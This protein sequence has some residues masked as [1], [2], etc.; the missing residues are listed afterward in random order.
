[1]AVLYLLAR[2]QERALSLFERLGRRW[3]W[4]ARR[5][6]KV[7]TSFISGLS[8]LTDGLRF[9]YAV[10]WMLINWLVAVVQY[11][12]MVKA[13]FPDARLLWAAFSLGV[14]ALGIACPITER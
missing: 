3:P 1:M 5:G 10:G 12:V 2:N 7:I 8:I 13:F 4:L 11:Y 9:L 6:G 14:A